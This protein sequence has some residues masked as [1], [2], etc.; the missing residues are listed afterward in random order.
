MIASLQF[1]GLV[2]A[3]VVGAWARRKFKNPWVKVVF[4][5]VAVIAGNLVYVVL[6]IAWA[7][8]NPET[9]HAVAYEIGH[10]GWEVLGSTVVGA[11]V[12]L[13][14]SFADRLLGRVAR[15]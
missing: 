14:T 3:F 13:L 4:F 2:V 8:A 6:G 9:L 12:G 11:L 15:S 10:K 5:F 7:L 1:I